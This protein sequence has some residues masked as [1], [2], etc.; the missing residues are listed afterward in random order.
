MSYVLV[1]KLCPRY[2]HNATT[3]TPNGGTT[4]SIL[5]RVIVGITWNLVAMELVQVLGGG[6]YF[7]S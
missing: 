2:H 7:S 3:P 4:S 6:A 1:V 5:G